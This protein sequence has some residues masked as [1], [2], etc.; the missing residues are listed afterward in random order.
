MSSTSGSTS[1]SS[2]KRTAVLMTGGSGVL[3]TDLR[4]HFGKAR[5]LS[6]VEVVAPSSGDFN[7][8]DLTQMET[9]LDRW[10]KENNASTG[11]GGTSSS[12]GR[13]SS[14]SSST[15][16]R[17]RASMSDF[18]AETPSPSQKG[19]SPD[20]EEMIEPAQRAEADRRK[21]LTTIVHLAAYVSTVRMNEAAEITKGID[22]NVIGTSN[23]CKLALSTDYVFDGKKAGG[24]YTESDP[25]RPL[26]NYGWSKLGGECVVQMVP[27]HLI[28]RCPF[29]PNVFP[30]P[31]AF[32]DQYTSRQPVRVASRDVAK[33]LELVLSE[34]LPNLNGIVHV[35]GDRKTVYEYACEDAGAKDVVG[36]LKLEDVSDMVS[37]A[38]DC[39]LDCSRFKDILWRQRAAWL[40]PQQSPRTD[41]G[42]A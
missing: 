20:D 12:S 17:A 22:T 19:G 24:L 5:L 40:D 26:N 39:S 37:L 7:V 35:A 42:V 13:A 29:G 16:R 8:A 4:Q 33:L 10:C 2:A 6:H 1:P 18:L 14:A 3:G 31:K 30:Y 28:I 34:K 11:G 15:A 9:Y 36:K 23:V 21:R 38:Q 27:R 41:H 25:T 32:V